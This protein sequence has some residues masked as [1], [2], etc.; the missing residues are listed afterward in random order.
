MALALLSNPVQ[1]DSLVPAKPEESSPYESLRS[2]IFSNDPKKASCLPVKADLKG[3]GSDLPSNLSEKIGEILQALNK[4]SDRGLQPLFHPRLNTSLGAISTML[5]K[6]DQTYGKPL[7]FSIARIWAVNTVDGNPKPLLCETEHVELTPMYGYPLQFGLW[8]Q[9]L[10][11]SELGR[12]YISLVPT[13]DGWYIGAWHVMQW[14]HDGKDYLVWAEEASKEK[15]PQLAYAKFDIA[16]KLVEGSRFLEFSDLPRLTNLRDQVLKKEHWEKSIKE[17]IPAQ[18]FQVVRAATLLVPGGAGVLL[19][20]EFPGEV[21]LVKMKEICQKI[22]SSVGKLKEWQ[23]FKGIRCN[24][25]LPGEDQ[26]QDGVQ[27]GLF[28]PF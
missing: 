10:G 4:G 15:S 8:V 14:T 19:G 6:L 26:K 7:Q 3:R 20:L 13:V 25:Y 12:I 22:S 27:G 5:A 24:F 28:V 18:G 17:S 16:L 21:S 1:G 23:G 11:V 9:V 2:K